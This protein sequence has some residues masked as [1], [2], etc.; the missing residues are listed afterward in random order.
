VMVD[1]SIAV[2]GAEKLYAQA[3]GRSAAIGLYADALVRPAQLLRRMK[4][5]TA[6]ARY[7]AVVANCRT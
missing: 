2:P 3:K 6:S 4:D 1:S 7:A 5:P